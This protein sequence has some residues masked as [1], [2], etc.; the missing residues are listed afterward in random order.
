M[1]SMVFALAAALALSAGCTV[2][3]APRPHPGGEYRPQYLAQLDYPI[4]GCERGPYA[5]ELTND[6]GY[7][8]EMTIDGESIDFLAPEG[9]Y[10]ELPPWTTAYLCL[11]WLGE[12]DVAG[13]SYYESYGELYPVRGDYGYFAVTDYYGSDVGPHGRQELYIDESLLYYY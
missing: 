4:A 9:A 6:T 10:A 1:K 3:V 11:E 13:Y 12:H 2:E 7:Y 8:L 5:L